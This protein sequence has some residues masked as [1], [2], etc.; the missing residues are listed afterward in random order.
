MTWRSGACRLLSKI[1]P[2]NNEKIT[3]VKTRDRDI[4]LI[5]LHYELVLAV[6]FLHENFVKEYQKDFFNIVLL[7]QVF[8]SA[9]ISIHSLMTPLTTTGAITWGRATPRL[10]LRSS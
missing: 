1:P 2:Q 10:L 6:V 3:E 7:L 8:R 4:E 9:G 5:R